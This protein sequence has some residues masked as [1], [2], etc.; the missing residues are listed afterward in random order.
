MAK[1]GPDHGPQD[2]GACRK[3]PVSVIA[4]SRVVKVNSPCEYSCAQLTDYAA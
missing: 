4:G 2:P 3:T 1:G